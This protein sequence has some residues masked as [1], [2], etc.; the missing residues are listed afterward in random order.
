MEE[1]IDR[2]NKIVSYLIGKDLISRQSPQKDIAEKIKSNSTNVSYALNGNSRYLTDSFLKRTNKAFGSIFNESWL[3]TGEGDMLIS[4][5]PERIN[6]EI[7]ISLSDIKEGEKENILNDYKLVPMI[8]LDAVGGLHAGNSVMDAPEYIMRT[9]AFNDA[10]KEDRCIQVTGH[11]MEPAVIPGSIVLIRKVEQWKE[12]FG[13]GNIFVI[14]LS[15]G[16]R[17]IKQVTRSDIDPKKYVKCVSFNPEYPE[18][19]LPK[20]MILGVW[21]VIKILTNRGW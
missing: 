18:E 20:D 19:D 2:I 14:L 4:E 6:K 21:K 13:F 12:Y 15:D 11:S 16:R 7:T 1:K 9:V 8:N 10:N 3:L 5:D 17:I